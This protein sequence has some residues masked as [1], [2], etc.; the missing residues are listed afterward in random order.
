M[1]TQRDRKP[2]KSRESQLNM[3]RALTVGHFDDFCTF[4]W[5]IERF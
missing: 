3:Y 2:E 4:A 5:P 1:T